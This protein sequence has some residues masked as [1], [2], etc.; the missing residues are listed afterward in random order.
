MAFR[1]SNI[2]PQ[3]AYQI[4]KS[5]AVQLKLN[6]S[7]MVAQLASSNAS[8]EFL[9]DIYRTLSRAHGQ[10]VELST[11]A[12][13]EAYAK[14]QENDPA[15]DVGAEFVSMQSAIVTTIQ[16]MDANVPTAVTVNTPSAWGD[17]A[18]IATT[19]TPEQTAPLRTALQAVVTAID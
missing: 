17:G 3:Q 8:Y 9:R 1:A 7:A 12:G 5:A 2:V 18:M 10:F 15:Y 19:F 6:V 11:T 13:L 16:W 14:Q 4:V